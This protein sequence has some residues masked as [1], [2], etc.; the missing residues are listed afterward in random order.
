MLITREEAIKLKPNGW[1]VFKKSHLFYIDDTNREAGVA[2][3][4][5]EAYKK[6]SDT[7]LLNKHIEIID[8]QNKVNEFV[9]TA[10]L[11]GVDEFP[12]P[13]NQLNFGFNRNLEHLKIGCGFELSLKS[14]LLDAGY[15]IHEIDK[16]N[17][18]YAQIAK[19]QKN[20]PI[21]IN[22]L[23][24]IS[25]YMF[26]GVQNILPGITSKSISFSTI[27]DKNSYTKLYSLDSKS[28]NIIKEY[29][30][31]RNAVHLPGDIVETYTTNKMTWEDK[32]TFLKKYINEQIVMRNRS[33]LKI[34]S[35][36]SAFYIDEW[37]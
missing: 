11:L 8:E 5:F 33:I 35:L 15:I 17:P 20:K 9:K 16:S 12:W 28:L 26:N 32:I 37:K 23:L 22:E 19:V 31:L 7:I 24:S 34:H 18:K 4:N 14:K 10:E 6:F 29:R 21:K 36:H 27:V 30:E 1:D 3:L 25:G 2:E 13:N